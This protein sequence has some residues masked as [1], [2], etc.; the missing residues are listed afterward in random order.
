MKDILNKRIKKRSSFQ[1]FCPSIL[2]VD[3]KKIFDKSY[4]NP[5]MTSVFKLKK[6]F[7][8]I[9]KSVSHIN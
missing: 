7:V 5:F 3:R 8:N 1:P 9:F 2:E 4:Y 6:E